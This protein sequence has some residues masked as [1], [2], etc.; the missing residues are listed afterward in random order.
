MTPSRKIA[1]LTSRAPSRG[2]ERK[3]VSA[4]PSVPNLADE[5]DAA[6]HLT[7][8]ERRVKY[9]CPGSTTTKDHFAV[10]FLP[11]RTN[12]SHLFIGVLRSERQKVIERKGEFLCDCLPPRLVPPPYFDTSLLAPFPLPLFTR[13]KSLSP[14]IR[15]SL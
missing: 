9:G 12:G 15:T 3:N 6:P 1:A 14:R 7:F 4:D 10:S 8:S 5:K 11:V 2:T 13:T